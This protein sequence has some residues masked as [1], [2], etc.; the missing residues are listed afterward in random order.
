MFFGE[1]IRTLR[2]EKKMSQI[3]MAKKLQ[4][5]S[6]ALS[7]YELNKRMPDTGMVQ[8]IADFFNVTTDYILGRTKIKNYEEKIYEDQEKYS[9]TTRQIE[10]LS[11]DSRKELQKYIELLKIKESIEKTE[12]ETSSA[13]EKSV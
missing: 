13:L 8:K 12:E 7:Q 10:G 9:A 4:I 5:T 6:Q 1:K 11:E 2:E 3:E